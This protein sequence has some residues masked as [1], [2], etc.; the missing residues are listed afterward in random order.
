MQ[1]PL[2]LPGLIE[3]YYA[4]RSHFAEGDTGRREICRSF[5]DPVLGYLGWE[6]V[7][8]RGCRTRKIGFTRE[9]PVRI[10]GRVT[11]IDYVLCTGSGGVLAIM[12]GNHSAAGLFSAKTVLDLR[13]YAWSAGLRLAIFTNFGESAVYDATIPVQ[14]GDDEAT[15]R[16]ATV[17]ADQFVE[18]WDRIV[19]LISRECVLRGSRDISLQEKG[20]EEKE[21]GVGQMLSADLEEWRLHL[22][23]RIAL[24][25]H[26][27]SAES[28]NE[29]VQ[30]II[31]RILFLRIAEDRGIG[32][33]GQLC[34]V[35]EGG[36][37]YGR[38]CGLFR[39]AE[40]E[41]G[42]GLFCFGEGTHTNESADTL[43]LTL[44]IDDEPIKNIITQ[45]SPPKS[46]Y[47][48][49]VIPAQILAEAFSLFLGKVIRLTPGNHALVEERPEIRKA[50]G[51]SGTPREIAEYIV[52]K[53]LDERVTGKTPRDLAGIHVLDP[54]CGSG[55][56]LV[57]A[58]EYLLD[59]HL[60]WY[61]DNLVP[62]IERGDSSP[63]EIGGFLHGPEKEGEPGRVLP[64]T[65]SRGSE[66]N[67]IREET[68]WELTADERKRI[69]LAMIFGVDIDMRAVQTTRLLLLVKFIES[70]DNNGG[71]P[72]PDLSGTIRCG[73]SLVGSDIVE[74]PDAS[75]IDPRSR[76]RLRVFDWEDAFPGIM[77]SGGFDAVVGHLPRFRRETLRGEKEYLEKRY[78]TYSG[79]AELYHCFIEKG[80][81]LLRPG[82]QFSAI[83]P[84]AWLRA[85]HGTMLRVFLGGLGIR[86]II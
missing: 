26:G 82:G 25:N 55:L 10:S 77:A 52:R 22:A 46:P 27:L 83:L 58:F 68:I 56:F 6:P 67:S 40:D 66:G 60:S 62:A 72:L 81:S 3:Q 17:T 29:V 64:V 7:E 63:G 47:E 53:T 80:I 21:C 31:T 13:R 35:T 42:K 41:Y 37:A 59:W 49:S 1:A 18:R 65:R 34:R 12:V 20:D 8:S 69:L 86:E 43:T 38:L 23:K 85:D 70:F 79:T 44:L 75:L 50:G 54:A 16:I 76:E 48:F 30:H 4:R 51:P 19:G 71:L 61:T 32:Q 11:C 73:N 33:Y 9:V 28:I 14:Y 36:F 39:H 45:L 78:R 5:I 74:D 2:S 24:R 57:N 15:A 84:D